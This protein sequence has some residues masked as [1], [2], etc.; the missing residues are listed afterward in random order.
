MSEQQKKEKDLCAELAAAPTIPDVAE[1]VPASEN[2]E[3]AVWLCRELSAYPMPSI[4]PEGDGAIG[5]DWDEGADRV[6]SVTLDAQKWI[7]Y[8]YLVGDYKSC[9]LVAEVAAVA[10]IGEVL[11]LIYPLAGNQAA[12]GVSS[13]T[14]ASSAQK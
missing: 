9:G 10:M 7:G 11:R 6:L 1:S 14:A 5:L 13:P 8:S 2:F 12:T 3:R 4:V